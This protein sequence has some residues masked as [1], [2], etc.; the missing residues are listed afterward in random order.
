VHPMCCV[1]IDV[2]SDWGGRASPTDSGLA[3]CRYS[4]PRILDLF[5]RVGARCTFFVSGEVA[6][7]ISSELRDIASRGHEIASHGRRHVRY[8]RLSIS[9]LEEELQSSKDTLEDVTGRR[10]VGFRSPYFAP[11]SNLFPALARAGY[12]YDSSLVA[13]RLPGRYNNKIS[14]G[15]F[16]KESILEIPIGRLPFTPLPS[17]LLW[18]NLLR[19]AVP[20]SWLP[21]PSKQLGVFY[22]HPFDLYPAKYTPL[23]DWKVN[24]WY[25]F[26]QKHACATLEAYLQRVGKQSQF[27]KMQ[28]LFMQHRAR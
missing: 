15:P 24:L 28:D 20:L 8:D 4:I 18:L 10:I 5:D 6:R 12:E 2:E 19:S 3:G 27:V 13:G 9:G 23:F 7:A 26:G 22:L 17:G 16:W 1:T 21:R 11:H 25:L 14:D